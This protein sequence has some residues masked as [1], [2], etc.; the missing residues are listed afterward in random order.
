MAGAQEELGQARERLR[1]MRAALVQTPGADPAL[2]KRI[3]EVGATLVGLQTRLSGDRT[4]RQLNES[5]VPS[6]SSRVGRVIGGHWDT[7]QTPTATQRRNL[8]IAREE[9]TVLRQELTAL[10]KTDLA[11]LELDL[12]EAGAP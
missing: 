3:D 10:P 6:I 4:R 2:Y 9:F 12:E 11:Q 5:T 1:Y 8:A 7:R